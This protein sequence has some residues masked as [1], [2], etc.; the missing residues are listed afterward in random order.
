[1]DDLPRRKKL[2]LDE[3]SYNQVGSYF[4]TVV[5]AQR[6][7]IFGQVLPSTTFQ[8]AF[9]ELSDIGLLVKQEIDFLMNYHENIMVDGFVIMP[10][11]VHLMLSISNSPA[12]DISRIIR[13]WKGSITK[14]AGHSIWHRSFHDHVVRNEQDYL[15]LMQ[16]ME[17]NPAQWEL[18]P[19]N[20]RGGL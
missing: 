2:R 5:A 16:Y 9:V 11:H 17:N 14:K 20:C 12:P 8:T 3:Y 15:R 10:N 6:R 19:L 7:L 18:D 4:I 1:M 13:L